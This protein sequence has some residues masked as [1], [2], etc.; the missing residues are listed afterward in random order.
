MHPSQKQPVCISLIGKE[1]QNKHNPGWGQ[2]EDKKQLSF[3]LQLDVI[4]L[5]WAPSGTLFFL[6]NNGYSLL[7]CDVTCPFIQAGGDMNPEVTLMEI[8]YL[9]NIYHELL[10]FQA[11]CHLVEFVRDGA[12]FSFSPLSGVF[13][14]IWCDDAHQRLNGSCLQQHVSA[15]LIFVN[16]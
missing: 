5:Y 1:K 7:S 13:L 9:N 2:T 6:N 16:A 14:F 3:E 15:L 10:G 11:L 4:D 8:K 12:L